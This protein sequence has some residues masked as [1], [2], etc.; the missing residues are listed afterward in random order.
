[1]Q[2][3]LASM[4]GAVNRLPKPQTF[5]GEGA[6]SPGRGCRLSGERIPTPGERI[7]TP[8][9][10]IPTPGGEVPTSGMRVLTRGR[11]YRLYEVGTDLRGAGAV[12]QVVVSSRRR[13]SPLAGLVKSG[14]FAAS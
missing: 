8:G 13:C 9:E 6:G 2:G 4:Q 12:L 11:G 14:G 3:S 1:M 7:P 10:G 5:R